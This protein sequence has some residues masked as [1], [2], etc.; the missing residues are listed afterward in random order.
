MGSLNPDTL[1]EKVYSDTY[2]EDED[3]VIDEDTIKHFREFLQRVKP[4]FNLDN[5]SSDKELVETLTG[6]VNGHSNITKD[7]CHE[8]HNNFCSRICN[9]IL[10]SNL[11]THKVIVISAMISFSTILIYKMR[12]N[13]MKKTFI[14][15]N[16]FKNTNDDKINTDMKS[17]SDI[18]TDIV[19]EKKTPHI[20]FIKKNW[21]W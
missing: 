4:S 18:D 15:N 17:D 2:F 9:K 16:E 12:T 13:L 21:F 20:V 3:I 14:D 10:T 5:V 6:L 1:Y 11:L 19:S 8:S 7:I